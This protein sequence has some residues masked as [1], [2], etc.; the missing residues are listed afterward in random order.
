[1]AHQWTEED[2]LIVLYLYKYGIEDLPC[3]IDS[4]ARE[5]GMSSASLRMRIGNMKA[6]AEGSGL[7]HY[8]KITA[9]VYLK[10][11]NA[12]NRRLRTVAF[13]ELQG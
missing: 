11:K 9:A 1:M 3:T 8:G 10:W 7:S 5:R 2:D 4:I 12:S 6:I 13:P